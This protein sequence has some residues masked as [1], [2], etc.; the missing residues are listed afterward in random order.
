MIFYFADYDME[1]A[2]TVSIP[3]NYCF[4]TK[5]M[6]SDA[7]LLDCLV[8]KSV[9]DPYERETV[10]A[11]KISHKQNERL[12]SLISRKDGSQYRLFLEALKQTNQSQLPNNWRKL[13]F[14]NLAYQI[15]TDFVTVQNM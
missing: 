9:L 10:K 5:M 15:F 13:V 11:E 1:I 4:L 7:G 8:A 2:H 3:R 6:E 14:I 12:L